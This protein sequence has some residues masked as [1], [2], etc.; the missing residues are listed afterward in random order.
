LLLPQP[1][2]ADPRVMFFLIFLPRPLPLLVLSPPA[3]SASS[4][5]VPG[6]VPPSTSLHRWRPPPCPEAPLLLLLLRGC[7]GRREL[8]SSSRAWRRRSFSSRAWR[9]WRRSAG[10][11]QCRRTAA[12]M[13]ASPHPA[14]T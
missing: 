1:S 12:A 6:A 13:R 14:R 10:G 11:G 5:A 3:S 7:V 8:S 2:R 9:A 4:A